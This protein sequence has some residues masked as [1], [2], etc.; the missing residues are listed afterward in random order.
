[1]FQSTDFIGAK[2]ILFLGP[3]LLVLRRDDRPDIPWPGFLDFP[4]GGREGDETPEACALRE[5]QEEVGLRISE[6]QLL[7]KTPQMRPKGR[8]WF[9]AARLPAEV[10]RDVRFGDEGT[11]WQMMSPTRYLSAPDA[12]PHFKDQLAAFLATG[13]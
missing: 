5:T 4:G 12:I 3:R 2:L 1:M 8:S 10:E 7:W 13:R 6:N 11:G 9:F